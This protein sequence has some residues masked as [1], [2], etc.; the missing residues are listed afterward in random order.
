ML[1]SNEHFPAT[2]RIGNTNLFYITLLS[3]KY[4][5]G[6]LIG[7]LITTKDKITFWRKEPHPCAEAGHCVIGQIKLPGT[8]S[9]NELVTQ[10]SNLPGK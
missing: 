6:K 8:E 10:P 2:L 9:V 3:I 4:F 7:K 5:L 1:A